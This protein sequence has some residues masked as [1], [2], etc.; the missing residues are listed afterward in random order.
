MASEPVRILAEQG[1]NEPLVTFARSLRSSGLVRS[2]INF[3]TPTMPGTSATV[4]IRVDCQRPFISFAAM[5]APSPDW[6]VAKA[7]ENMLNPAGRFRGMVSGP[8]F[9]YDSGTDSGGDFTPPS[10]LSLDIP[11]MPQQNIVP[12]REDDTDVFEGEA[13]GRFILRRV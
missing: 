10:D 5:L 12:L 2:V 6:I 7:R 11:T 3:Q 13:V 1:V 8:L 9:T 4:R